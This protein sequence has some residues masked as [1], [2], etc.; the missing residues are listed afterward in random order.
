M[1]NTLR[2]TFTKASQRMM[3]LI[4]LLLLTTFAAHAQFTAG[5]LVV[6]QTSGASSKGS[7]PVTLKEYATNGTAG[8]SLS[9]PSTGATPI[10]IAAGAGG[11]EGFLT[12]TPDGTNLVLAGYFTTA[13]F[14]DI[15]VTTATVAPRAIYKVDA[16]GNF[17]MVDSSKIFYTANDIRGAIS[18]GTNYWASGAS[19]AI[20]GI[21]YYSPGTHAA[22]ATGAKA[23]GLQLFNGQIYFSTQKTG[24]VTPTMGIYA[25]GTGT[26]TSGTVS[27]TSIINTGTATPED[28]SFNAAGDVCYVAINLN[29]IVGGIQKWTKSGSTWSL[30]YTLH[31]GVTS[32]GAYG[33]AVD[34]SGVNPVLYATTSEANTIGNR[35]I[36]ITDS[37]STATATTLVAGSTTAYF[38]GISFAPTCPLPLQ[39]A[40]FTAS[41]TTVNPGQTAVT[42]TVPNDPTVTYNWTYS[43][44]GETI[45]GTG[46]SVTINFANASTAGTLDVTAT[47]GCGTSAARGTAITIAGTM[48]ITEYMYNGLGTGSAGEYIEFTNIGGT[49][50]DM[51]GW[52]FDDNTRTPGS[53]SLSSFGTVQPGESVIL[54]ELTASA[55][56]SNW[57]LCTGVK[58][59]GG[60]TSNNLGRADEINLYD[61]N[62][63]QIDRL[64]YDDQTY[65]GTIRTA[66][67]SG[68]VSDAGL[69]L[70]DI[71]KW[72]YSVNG[73]A[74]ASYASGVAEIGSPGKSTRASVAYNPCLVANGSP[75][76]VVDV[77][78][79][80][81]YLDGGVTVAPASPYPLSGV[82]SDPS[83]P[84]KVFGIAFTVNDAETDAGSLI[85]TATSSNTT[86]VPNANLVVSGSTASRNVT[87]TPA[88]VGY[89]NITVSVSDGVNTTSFIISYASS[90]ASTTPGA[91][92][93]HTGM[94]D[95][96]EAI[97]QDDA[98]Y[99]AIDDELNVL[100]VYSKTRS[101]LPYVSF[102]YTSYLN[103]PNPAKPEVDLEA[104]TRSRS[105]NSKIYWLG[106][107]SNSK[108]PFNNMPNRDRLFATTVNGTGPS[109]TF[110]FGGYYGNLRAQLLTWGDANG[111]DF[112]SSAAAGV[113]SKSTSG[114]AAEGMVF[115]PDNSTL[116]IGLRAPLV[117]T[118]TRTKAVIAPIVNFEGWFNNGT[119]TGN[120]VF[121]AP[122]ELDLG[123]RGI[124]GMIRMTNG[125]FLIVA[126]NSGGDPITSAIFKWSGYATDAP[127]LVNTSGNNILNMEGVMQ[128][129]IAGQ[130]ALDQVQVISDGGDDDLYNDGSEAKDFADLDLRKFRNDLLSGVDLCLST[131]STQTTSACTS[132]TWNS[133]TYTSSDTYTVHLTNASGCDSAATLQLTIID[134]PIIDAG[135]DQV[136][137]ASETSVQ[138]AGTSSNTSSQIWSTS[139]SGSFDPSVNN[140]NATYA[141]S[142][143]DVA[144]GGVVLTL[145]SDN[146]G[147]CS[148]PVADDMQLSLSVCTAVLGESNSSLIQLIPNPNS[149]QAVITLSEGLQVSELIIYGMNGEEVKTQTISPTSTSINL[150]LHELKMGVY[151]IMLKDAQ[152]NQVLKRMVKN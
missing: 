87:I 72:S 40:D 85:F 16:A 122:I 49:A 51:S 108:A 7:S 78:N 99:I 26:P 20:D 28:F 8:T 110:T 91:T 86:V 14:S 133:T 24:S 70:N 129:N 137:C 38:H 152:G 92:V 97:S 29:T 59:I 3:R 79:T 50:V 61:N 117:P 37:N 56:R 80:N 15:T 43:G 52:S 89:A 73:D 120:P 93:W 68:W 128:V 82:I 55:F 48:R 21:N 23:Y 34:Y 32:V 111:Y 4:A 146:T 77:A 114:F 69:G 11:S 94:S 76:I 145:T 9:L 138:L 58:V 31:T 75:T 5:R 101:G 143:T 112:T 109:T 139:G 42:Y 45:T 19:N 17:S 123:G 35:I 6:V 67:K 44:T 96:S 151:M 81:N 119:P 149:G 135:A 144:N 127:V 134:A 13:T 71:T 147:I 25:L 136:V 27:A 104:A 65:S 10:Q 33:L 100:N 115:G 36:S 47:N 116:Y 125:T 1:M 105:D 62:N 132:Y 66:G 2:N 30:A 74:E 39:P 126:G 148:T 84:A 22:L 64:T 83:D 142:A 121:A 88:A 18:D 90:G 131:Q 130:P 124:R 106:S 41:T 141:P 140:V 54:T 60:N 98:Y 118:A 107:M 12:R 103:L 113:D 63:N 53:L 95:A 102:D 150:D 57:S 46:N